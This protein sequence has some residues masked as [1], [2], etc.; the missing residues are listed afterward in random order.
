MR[1]GGRGLARCAGACPGEHRSRGS[2]RVGRWEVRPGPV[3]AMPWPA[4]SAPARWRRRRHQAWCFQHAL[5]G[6]EQRLLQPAQGHRVQRLETAPAELPVGRVAGRLPWNHPPS[7]DPARML[8]FKPGKAGGWSTAHSVPPDS[9]SAVPGHRTTPARKAPRLPGWPGGSV[10]AG[11]RSRPHRTVSK[12]RAQW[13][14]GCGAWRKH[15]PG[16]VASA[17]IVDESVRAS[18]RRA[19]GPTVA[20]RTAAAAPREGR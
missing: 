2:D 10:P 11:R 3:S 17:G 20:R 15:S 14:G 12:H 18:S 13:R 19:T 9:G 8:D 5:F 6:L 4:R 16:G 7:Y 1:S